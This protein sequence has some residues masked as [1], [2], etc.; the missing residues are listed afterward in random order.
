[1]AT[2][3]VTLVGDDWTLITELPSMLQFSSEMYMHITDGAAPTENTGFIMETNEKYV[4]SAA[5]SIW[6]KPIK[7]KTTI[8]SVRVVE[9]A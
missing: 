5:L 9:V 7:N 1:M 2:K 3:L 6:A 8:K 4:S